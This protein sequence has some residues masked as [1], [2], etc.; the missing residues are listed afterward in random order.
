MTDMDAAMKT[1]DDGL[2]GNVDADFIALMIPHH[3]G[4]V[5]MARAEILHGTDPALK[6]IAQEI[7]AEQAIEIQYLQKIQTRLLAAHSRRD[8]PG[9]VQPTSE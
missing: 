8:D 2:T 6:N 4:A 7:V 9:G 5:D 3:Q 1:A